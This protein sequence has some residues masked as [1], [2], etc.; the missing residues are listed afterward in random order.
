MIF[1]TDFTFSRG[2]VLV[3]KVFLGLIYSL[4]LWCGAGVLRRLGQLLTRRWLASGSLDAPP[5]YP[6]LLGQQIPCRLLLMTDCLS[7]QVSPSAI[8]FGT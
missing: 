4:L 5:R 6:L 3:L 2:K 8:A 7:P 1:G